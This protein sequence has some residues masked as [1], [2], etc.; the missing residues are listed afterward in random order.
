MPTF[1]NVATA[2]VLAIL[3]G[4]VIPQERR[5]QAGRPAESR[6]GS[7]CFTK[8]VELVKLVPL[9]N[10]EKSGGENAHFTRV[11]AFE[12]GNKLSLASDTLF[13]IE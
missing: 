7:P 9:F 5:K 8:L 6:G 10:L 2:V 13:Y 12:S 1:Q 3:P 4:G 11:F